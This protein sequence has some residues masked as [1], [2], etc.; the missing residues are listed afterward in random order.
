MTE[1]IKEQPKEELKL[2]PPKMRQIIIETDGNRI[3]VLKNEVAGKLEF[4]AILESLLE[5]IS[6]N[7]GN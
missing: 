5:F 2:A 7:G 4:K 3:N 1:E 6:S